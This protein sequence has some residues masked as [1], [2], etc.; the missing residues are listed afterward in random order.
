MAGFVPFTVG[1]TLTSTV[2]NAAFNIRREV[3]QGA[4]DTVTNTTTLASSSFL[5]LP[6]AASSTYLVELFLLCDAAAAADMKF[7]FLFSGG[8]TWLIAPWG[9]DTTAT[10]ATGSV[11]TGPVN[12]VAWTY[13]TIGVGSTISAKPTGHISTTSAGNVTLQFAQN[14]ANASVA[15][16]QFGSHMRLTKVL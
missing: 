5:T 1:Q 3:F 14:T 12:T 6:V 7:S 15:S 8:G 2:L 9:Q 13:G 10:V 4:T 16:L 11:Q